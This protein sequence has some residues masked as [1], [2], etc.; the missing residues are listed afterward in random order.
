MRPVFWR[1]N[2]RS[3]ATQSGNHKSVK[4]W[5][6]GKQ[7]RD[8][9]VELM[10]PPSIPGYVKKPCHWSCWELEDGTRFYLCNHVWIC[11]ACGKHM[12]DTKR[13]DCPLFAPY[14]PEE[15]SF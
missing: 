12:K 6:M 11:V 5:C 14:V 2:M 4:K 13:E 8:H 10:V 3:R 1:K 15:T 9:T 7:G